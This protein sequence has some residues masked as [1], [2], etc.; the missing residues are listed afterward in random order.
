ME[1]FERWR[2]ALFN[3]K[4][5]GLPLTVCFKVKEPNDERI[6]DNLSSTI[7]ETASEV[8]ISH[9][10]SEKVQQIIFCSDRMGKLINRWI[11]QI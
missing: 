5:S 4:R 10:R 11:K 2:R 6:W 9:L 3:E 8:S 7:N 1:I